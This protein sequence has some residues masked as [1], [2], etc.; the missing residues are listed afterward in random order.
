MVKE[1]SQAMAATPSADYR[2]MT[3]EQIQQMAAQEQ[4]QLGQMA[5][6]SLAMNEQE[7]QQQQFDRQMQFDQI[8]TALDHGI[9]REKFELEKELKKAQAEYYRDRSSQ[10]RMNTQKL[11]TERRLQEVLEGINVSVDLGDGNIS[12]LPMLSAAQMSAQGLPLK[13]LT[14]PE[15]KFHFEIFEGVDED[16]NTIA[17]PIV[18]N[19]QTLETTT[20]PRQLTGVDK[21]KQQL[22]SNSSTGELMWIKEGDPIPE[23]FD[24]KAGTSTINTE[25]P[26][27]TITEESAARSIGSLRAKAQDTE[28]VDQIIESLPMQQKSLIKHPPPEPGPDADER[29][30]QNYTDRLEQRR[31]A[32]N[33]LVQR[34]TDHLNNLYAGE[35]GRRVAYGEGE[36]GVGF[37]LI[38]DEGNAEFI[39]SD[40][41]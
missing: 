37:Y 32:Q 34:M 24:F 20:G 33:S 23:G 6:L 17:T 26:L 18:F 10:T 35:D 36:R 13:I 1:L 8:K 12:E 14:E 27:E 28:V 40:I 3:P 30:R 11:M 25:K 4:S 2:G 31:Q 41:K 21:P 16:G 38:D 29:I 22:I 5:N 15:D 7:I 39:R 19:K 9:E